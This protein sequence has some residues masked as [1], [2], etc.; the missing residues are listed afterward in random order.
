MAIRTVANA[1]QL[2]AAIRS[3][4]SGDTIQL[5][6]G[7][8]GTVTIANSSKALTIE[9]ESAWNEATFKEISVIRS[10]NLTFDNLDFKGTVSGGWGTGNGMKIVDSR[11]IKVE[12]S[13][14][15]DYYKGLTAVR[16]QGIVVSGNEITRSSEDGM[17]FSGVNGLQVIGNE[18]NGMKAPT[19]AHHDMIQIHTASGASSNVVIRGNV[20]DSNDLQTYGITFFGG[21]THSNI[22]IDNNKVIAGHHHGITVQN[23]NG[24]K[25]TNNIV[26]KDPG[27][28]SFRDI[29]TPEINVGSGSR[30]VQ[31]TGNT[32]YDIN[33]SAGGVGSNR[34]VSESVKFS[35][36]QAPS[37]GGSPSSPPPSSPPPSSP[38]A[39]SLGADDV[40]RF[41]GGD[42]RGWTKEIA[43]NVDLTRDELEFSGYDRGT[44]KGIGG[45]NPLSV[46]ADGTS[47]T[48][49]SRAD[50][51]ELIAASPDISTQKW[52]STL[53][54]II[55]Q[56]DGTHSVVLQNV[57][58]PNYFL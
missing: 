43:R 42:V 22:T 37:V 12:D 40:F 32:T 27:N 3:A 23:A 17:A 15:Q 20:L 34:I 54:L 7:N 41:D 35:G 6:A 33:S 50:V 25:I 44:F 2:N 39:P 4:S 11:N 58:D 53:A 9:F 8:Y 46:S 57:G 13:E 49:D 36:S 28:N 18:I 19:Q 21:V 14:F 5:K 56:D 30:N 45:G 1:S 10:S 26:L 47:A 16:S 48:I 24:L 52:G 38:S 51:K 31:I 29:D 55:D